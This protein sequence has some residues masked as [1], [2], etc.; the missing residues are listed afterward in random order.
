MTAVTRTKLAEAFCQTKGCPAPDDPEWHEPWCHGV[1]RCFGGATHQHTVKRSQGGKTIDAC[2]CAGMH[3]AVDNGTAYANKVLTFDDGERVYRL[4]D[5]KTGEILIDRQIQAGD[6]NWQGASSEGGGGSS[7]PNGK[8]GRLS[9]GASVPTPLS[10]GASVSSEAPHPPEDAGRTSAQSLEVRATTPPS[11][12]YEPYKYGDK[13]LEF[14]PEITFEQWTEA[15]L[16]VEG[17]EANHQWWQGDAANRGEVFG[18]RCWQYLDGK[19]IKF[20]TLRNCMRVCKVYPLSRRRGVSFGHHALLISLPEKEQDKWLSEAA[21]K[22]WTRVRLREAAFGRTPKTVRWSLEDLRELFPSWHEN[23]DGTC[24]Q[25]EA[26]K[27]FLRWL[28]GLS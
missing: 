6:P 17:I 16:G 2:L 15:W 12:P 18:D 8:L 5:V 24:D 28:G 26:I 3:D 11:V 22:G 4:W 21:D 13:G 20:S 1:H 27:D 9:T 19:G 25:C 10:P 23:C 7:T 14:E